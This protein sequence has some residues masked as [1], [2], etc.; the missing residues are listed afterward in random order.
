MEN[1]EE[2]KARVRRAYLAR[3]A[4]DVDGVLDGFTEDASLLVN[5]AGV[6]ATAMEQRLSGRPALRAAVENF[7]ENFRFDDFTELALIVE[8]DRGAC[9]WRANVVCKPTGRSAVLDAVDMMTFR[10]GRIS[11]LLQNTDTATLKSLIFG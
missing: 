10:D 7:V 9:H 11:D 5:A 2:L 3:A 6:G 1:V 8:G 4:G